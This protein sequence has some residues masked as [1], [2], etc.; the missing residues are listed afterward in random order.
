MYGVEATAGF[1][2]LKQANTSAPLNA[3]HVGCITW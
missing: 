2:A 3:G 1:L